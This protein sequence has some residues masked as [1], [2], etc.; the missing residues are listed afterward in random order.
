MAIVWHVFRDKT[1]EN[2]P[3]AVNGVNP[4]EGGIVARH[5]DTADTVRYCFYVLLRSGSSGGQYDD[6]WR[7]QNAAKTQILAPA[8]NLT[9]TLAAN[10]TEMVLIPPTGAS[11]SSF[12]DLE[13]GNI[14]DPTDQNLIGAVSAFGASVSA[15]F[16]AAITRSAFNAL[17]NGAHI[18]AEF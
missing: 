15:R 8:I 9:P 13:L 12:Q 1:E 5:D 4:I 7:V 17:V 18:Q 10:R 6:D 16:P 11:T 2:N 3:P 14:P